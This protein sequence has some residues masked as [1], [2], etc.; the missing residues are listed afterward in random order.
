MSFD[1][2]LI[3]FFLIAETCKIPVHYTK[4]KT[5]Q[6]SCTYKRMLFVIAR[7]KLVNPSQTKFQHEEGSRAHNP[8]PSQGAIGNS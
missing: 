5:Q 1:S 7:A 6:G 4:I 3:G 2:F 8:I